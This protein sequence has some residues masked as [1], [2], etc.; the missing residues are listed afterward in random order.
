VA[1]ADRAGMRRFLAR[2]DGQQL[3]AAL[4]ATTGWQF[5]CEELERVGAAMHLA[6]PAETSGL[7]GPK[8]RAKTDAAN[9]RHLRQL[10]IADRR[11]E[12]WIPPAHLLDLRARVR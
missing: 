5:V 1:P 11:P 12:S 6:E 9:A 4:E 3:E 2:F 8:H 7:R 10:L